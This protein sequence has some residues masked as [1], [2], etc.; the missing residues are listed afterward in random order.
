[1]A[2]IM[3]TKFGQEF[4]LTNLDGGWTVEDGQLVLSLRLASEVATILSTGIFDDEME[5]EDG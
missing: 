3:L 4:R 5:H 1:M 2:Q